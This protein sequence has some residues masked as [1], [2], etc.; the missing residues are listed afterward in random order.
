VSRKS[1]DVVVAG[2]GCFGA[3]T[4]W[5]LRA[6]GRSVLLVDQYGP[7]NARASSGGESRAIRMSYGPDEIYTRFAQRSLVL[8]KT[9]F[10]E[11]GRAELF[12]RTGV[13]WMAQGESPAAAASLRALAACGIRH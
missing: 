10:G 2:A 5:Q 13:L 11:I 3:W 6:A 9:F 7:A 12:Q 1:F 8:W 4:A